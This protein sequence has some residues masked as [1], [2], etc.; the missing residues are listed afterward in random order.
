MCVCHICTYTQMQHTYVHMWP[1]LCISIYVLQCVEPNWRGN[2]VCVCVFHWVEKN[3]F[4]RRNFFSLGF[5]SR[6]SSTSRY[7]LATISKMLKNI[8]LFAEYRSLLWGSFAL[9]TCV[10]KH[11]PHRSHPIYLYI[12]KHTF[13]YIHTYCNRNFQ[14]Y[15][16][17]WIWMCVYICS[18]VAAAVYIYTCALYMCIYTCNSFTA[19]HCNTLQHTATCALSMCI[20]TCAAVWGAIYTCAAVWGA[21]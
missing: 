15:V 19:T 7:W 5:P 20:Y 12:Y 14:V 13:T 3:F 17:M 16:R 10:F 9:E 1:L 2:G 4:F 18:H 21:Q 11:P 8:C 6:S